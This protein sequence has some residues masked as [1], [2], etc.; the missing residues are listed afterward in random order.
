MSTKNREL[1]ALQPADRSPK[2]RGGNSNILASRSDDSGA[3]QELSLTAQRNGN[4]DL[5]V[6]LIDKAIALDPLNA[7]YH[8]SRGTILKKQGRLSDA[9]LAYGE[10]LSI[11]PNNVEA[12]YNRAIAL[13]T[14]GEL[15]E[16]LAAYEQALRLK[17]DFAEAHNNR[18]NLLKA[19]DRLPE[20]LDAY[21]HAVRVNPDNAE[22]H[23]N[24]AITLQQQGAFDDA[25]A[26][27]KQA[28]SLKP[29]FAEAH[30]NVANIRRQQ[31]KLDDALVACN[32]A[33][34]IRPDYLEAHCNRGMLLHAQG[35][36]QDALVAYDRVLRIE[37]DLA[38]IH[39]YRGQAL[40]QLGRSQEALA[41]CDQALRIKPDLA[42]IQIA[43]GRI[44]GHEGRLDEALTAYQQ[45]LRRN[46][47]N[48]LAH[49][50]SGDILQQLGRF[51]EALAAYDQVQRIKPDLVELH[52][53]RGIALEA[54]GR[55]SEA[56][57]AYDQVLRARP[58][59]AEAHLNRGKTLSHLGRQHDAI[60]AYDRAIEIKPDMVEAYV[61]R[62]S[63][64]SSAGRIRE[65]LADSE[66][67]LR[68]D[69]G[70][71]EA[72]NNQLYVLQYDPSQ[73]DASLYAAHRKWGE[74]YDDL[75]NVYTAY[76]NPRDAQKI[77][78]VGLVSP[79]LGMHPVGYMILPLL[80]PANPAQVQ[81]ICYSNRA[82]EDALTEQLK[83]KATA[84]RTTVGVVDSAL[85]EHVRED[86]I[87]ILIDLAG[88]T[89]GNRLPV[90]A[91]K[92]APVQ[93][94]WLGYRSTTGLTAI[95]YV[96]SDRIMV[97]PDSEHGFV[98]QVVRLPDTRLC[99]EP[100]DFAP[101]PAPPPLL[102]RG[103]PTFGS[104]NNIIKL[105]PQVMQLWARILNALPESRLILKW[106]TFADPETRAEYHRRFAALGVVPE[107]IELRG[108]SSHSKMLEEYGDIDVLLDPYPFSG[109]IS[110]LE[111]LWQGLPIVTLSTA[112]PM[113]RQTQG[114]LNAL[115]R[116]EWVTSNEEDYRAIAVDLASDPE[117]LVS[118]RHEQ[119]SRMRD[120]T[121]CDGPRF[122]RH[123][124]LALRT[125]W[126]TWC[127][128]QSQK[129]SGN[130]NT[131]SGMVS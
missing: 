30:Y 123:F 121:L 35:A 75:S 69:P 55:S 71:Q 43:R 50:N 45:A 12:H 80:A 67:A 122:A 63:E 5:A 124:E 54:S 118:A 99:Y 13:E 131:L 44:L 127:D 86:Q 61:N 34:R 4:D 23:Y 15:N 47:D 79:D 104:F 57:E 77:L 24:C 6:S 10:A 36:L 16:A 70:C 39:L 105:T 2:V 19:L 98:E 64:L 129:D 73:D 110:S 108:R 42:E 53:N 60:A 102:E 103:W 8:N 32:Q 94:T 96:L 33:L 46:P 84:W 120:S 27:Y 130:P 62:G 41:A 25:L 72:Y 78:R 119:R 97:P 76:A 83:S 40:V 38:Q 49:N 22:V 74:Q 18:G 91:L 1:G 9:L 85:A 128:Q 93:V 87:D 20:A 100:R 58:D 95:D 65:A 51:E 109:G 68:I 17:P 31:G 48:L 14:H 56:L 117:R 92:P 89:A 88:H 114:F 66:Q 116:S 126:R 111:A 37:P 28:L 106:S 3:L 29:D 107:R 115:G 101:P 81:F 7:V 26:A 82:Q 112:H 125:M 52:V 11:D 21:G 90:F 113:S 59:I